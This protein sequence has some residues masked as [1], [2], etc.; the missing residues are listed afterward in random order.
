MNGIDF[1]LDPDMAAFV[2]LVRTAGLDPSAVPIETARQGARELRLPWNRGGPAMHHSREDIVAGLRCRV[3]FPRPS[4]AVDEPFTVYLHGG[5]WTLL[6]IDT[7][8]DLARRI[9]EASALPVL[10]VDYP[11]APESAFPVPLKRLVALLA[12]LPDCELASGLNPKRFVLSGDSAGANLAIALALALRE[13]KAQAPGALALLYGSFAPRFETRSH[14]AYGSGA[15]PL[16]TARMKWF[17]D[18]YVPNEDQR[19]DPLAVPSEGDL[20]G[21]PSIFLGVAQHDILF[22]ENIDLAARLAAAGVDLTLRSYPGTVHGF[23]EAAGAVGA[24]VARQAL[25][26]LGRFIAARMQEAGAMPAGA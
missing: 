11:R 6:D 18:N 24:A 2:Q 16:T 25:D 8:D 5:G 1:T 20:A 7:H 10:L 22:D 23:A 19:R 13:A 17:W 26:E 14:R 9:A 15:L 4:R 21:L 3:H 12:A